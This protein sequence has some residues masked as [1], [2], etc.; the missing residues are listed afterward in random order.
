MSYPLYACKCCG[1]AN[2]DMFYDYYQHLGKKPSEQE[3]ADFNGY[4]K[5]WNMLND[6]RKK[7]AEITSQRAIWPKTR[8]GRQHT[9]ETRAKISA[10]KTRTII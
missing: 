1:F 9:A 10:T 4:R 5:A 2:G 6:E 8:I 7:A 3:K